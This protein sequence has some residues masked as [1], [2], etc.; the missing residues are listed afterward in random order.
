MEVRLGVCT[1]VFAALV[2]ALRASGHGVAAE[3]FG[4]ALLALVTHGM[5]R[6]SI[7]AVSAEP[8]RSRP[9]A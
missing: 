5:T 9:S 4:V 7:S 3:F 8:L 2:V 6:S 1:V